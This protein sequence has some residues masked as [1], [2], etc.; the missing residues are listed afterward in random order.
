MSKTTNAVD[1]A[2]TVDHDT[3]EDHGD[4]SGDVN[5]DD[6]NSENG[7]DSDYDYSTLSDNDV[8]LLQHA[9]HHYQGR[10]LAETLTA[11]LESVELDK[12]LAL[13]AQ[14]SGQLNSKNQELVSKKLQLIERLET[15][16]QQYKKYFK[17]TNDNSLSVVNQIRNDLKLLEQRVHELKH[18]KSSMKRFWKE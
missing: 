4:T 14:I 6:A 2:G 17:P 9:S 5:V 11:T 8:G 10:Y 1:G 13:E 15:L 7:D 16:Q 3:Q 18:G 12:S